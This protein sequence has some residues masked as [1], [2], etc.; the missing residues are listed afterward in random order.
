MNSDPMQGLEARSVAADHA[1]LKLWLR[2]LSCVNE[3]EAEIR[4]RLRD[5]FGMS[6]PRFDYLAQLRRW[7][8][9]LKMSE[10]SK[11]L[12]MSGGNVT[13]LTDELEREGFVVRAQSPRD[14]RAW[15]IRL[16]APGR[17][18]FDAM[19]LAHERW[20]LELF[21]GLDPAMLKQTYQHLGVLRQGIIQTRSETETSA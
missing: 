6:L 10:L 1:A 5:A 15:I 14:R 13:M 17:R 20:I 3:L 21:A 19:A 18:R 8:D 12:M 4:R 11:H 7:P 9:G 2:M 16:T